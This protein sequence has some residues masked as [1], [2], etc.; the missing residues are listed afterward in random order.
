MT[1]PPLPVGG[2]RVTVSN[3]VSSTYSLDAAFQA[4]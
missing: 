4:N 3:S 1:T 2:V